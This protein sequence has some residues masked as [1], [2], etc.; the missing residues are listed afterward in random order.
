LFVTSRKV[1]LG[2]GLQ[3]KFEPLM[4]NACA[5]DEPVTGL[6]LTLVMLGVAAADGV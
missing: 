2:E 4:V 3:T 6:G 1:T 5:D